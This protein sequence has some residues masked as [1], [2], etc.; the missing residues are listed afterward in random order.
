[1][2]FLLKNVFVVVL[3]YIPGPRLLSRNVVSTNTYSKYGSSHVEPMMTRLRELPG[4]NIK[5]NQ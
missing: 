4:P 5:R 2:N 3:N 1:M